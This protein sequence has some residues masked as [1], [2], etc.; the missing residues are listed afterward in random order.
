MKLLSQL[1]RKQLEALITFK[2][3]TIMFPQFAEAYRR[4]SESLAL[5]QT[6]GLVENHLMHGHAGC[7][8]STLCHLLRG[9]HPRVVEAE[10]DVV[11]LLY[12]A[13]PALA[14]ISSVTEALLR[15]LGDP[16]PTKGTNS[17][18]TDRV[19]T[20]IEGCDVAMIILDEAQHVNDRGQSPTIY[21]VG[22]WIKNLADSSRRPIVLSGLPRVQGLINT[23][24]QLRRRFGSEL[25]LDRLI[26]DDSESMAEFAGLASSLID[27]LPVKCSLDL[28]REE[29]LERLYYATDGRVGYMASLFHRALLLTYLADARCIDQGVLEL[30]FTQQI[31]AGGI[32][33]LNPFNENF[34]FRRLDKLGEPFNDTDAPKR[35]ESKVHGGEVT[36]V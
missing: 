28:T 17:A 5:Y 8:K 34:C 14:T 18:K 31:W 7:G 26:L 15:E 20:L 2:R 12:A 29:V 10:R 30:A 3:E 13:V 23:N 4:I 22:D 19:I 1:S 16:L 33:K 9:E 35:K 27:A 32:G 21:K 25:T 6:T 11:P 36:L 24:E